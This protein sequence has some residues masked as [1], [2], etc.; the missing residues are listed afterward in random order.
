MTRVSSYTLYQ[1]PS[2]GQVH[3]KNE[4]GSISIYVPTDLHLEP[5]ENRAC[6]RCGKVSQVKDYICL[7]IRSK[8]ITV[9]KTYKKGI[10]G[11]LHKKIHE[12]YYSPEETDLNTLYPYI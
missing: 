10:F 9:Q 12:F 1:C 5:T 3:I 2:C 6:K 7:G 11:Q 8:T 4:Y